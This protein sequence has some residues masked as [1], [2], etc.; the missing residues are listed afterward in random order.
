M[1]TFENQFFS[2][3]SLNVQRKIASTLDAL[4]EETQRLESIYQQKLAALG[5][6]KNPCCT[7]HSV[8]NSKHTPGNATSA[9]SRGLSGMNL[10]IGGVKDAKLGDVKAA[11]NEFSGEKNANREIGAPNGAPSWHSRGYLPHFESSD[12]TQHVTF[13]F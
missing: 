13:H 2:F 9:P 11:P 10:P 8:A 4:R 7:R 12:V 5:A 1:G 6:L 3:P